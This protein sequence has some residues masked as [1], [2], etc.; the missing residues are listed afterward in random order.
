MLASC[1]A[2]PL[3]WLDITEFFC[4]AA[5]PRKPLMMKMLV[6]QEVFIV[7]MLTGFFFQDPQSAHHIVH[8]LASAALL[9]AAGGM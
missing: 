3:A 9:C 8:L 2:G 4:V 7:G 5:E 1:S 6:C